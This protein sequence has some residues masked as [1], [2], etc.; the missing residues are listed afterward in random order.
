MDA[1]FLKLMIDQLISA[2][3]SWMMLLI[4][5]AFLFK[6]PSGVVWQTPT[7][8]AT[9]S[10]KQSRSRRRVSL[11][12]GRTDRRKELSS[13][14]SKHNAALWF[15]NKMILQVLMLDLMSHTYS[16]IK[17][18]LQVSIRKQDLLRDCR[19]IKRRYMVHLRPSVQ[20]IH[21]TFWSYNLWSS[22]LLQHGEHNPVY[23]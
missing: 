11:G 10:Q 17:I 14:K 7:Q 4:I 8:Q 21:T 12:I 19:L 5:R 15:G 13:I 2:C 20:K 6:T 16:F 3:N 1:L 18:L 22:T 9:T 23:L